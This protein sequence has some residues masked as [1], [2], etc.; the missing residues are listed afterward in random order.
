MKFPQPFANALFTFK[1]I[2]VA[3]LCFHIKK[4]DLFWAF[5]V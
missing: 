5:S 4:V 1:N 2:G 3:F